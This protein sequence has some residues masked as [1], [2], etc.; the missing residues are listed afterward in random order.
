M[1]IFSWLGSEEAEKVR[2]S[3]IADA[4][5]DYCTFR[6][7]LVSLFGRFELE[8]AFLATLRNLRHSGAESIAAFSARTTNLCSRAYPNFSTEDQLSLAV[9]HFIADV[10]SREC[11]QREQAR[12]TIEWQ[13]AIRI[14]QASEA[15]RLSDYVHS[16]A[17]AVANPAAISNPNAM[18][19]S[20]ATFGFSTS[21][22]NAIASISRPGPRDKQQNAHAPRSK[23]PR[24]IPDFVKAKRPWSLQENAHAHS[25]G[26]TRDPPPY[27]KTSDV[28]AAKEMNSEPS[29]PAA[30]S[31]SVVCYKCGKRG[32]ISSGCSSELKPR[33]CFAC[34]GFG[35]I[36]RNCPS[37]QPQ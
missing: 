1:F 18:L 19:H 7:G 36:S 29:Q 16:T 23:Q 24:A 10:S 21:C 27:S 3:H 11:L 6:K 4:V 33:R 9:D 37:R 17:A 32:H 15:A 25:T 28:M 35:H 30:S 2:R 20:D 14:A 31:D 22:A 5:A 34:S 8:G 26:N 12:R 13:E